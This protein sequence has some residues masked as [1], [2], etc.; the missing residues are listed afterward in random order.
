MTSKGRRFLWDHAL[1]VAAIS[2][3]LVVVAFFLLS[4][5]IPGWLLPP[6]AHDLLIRVVREGYDYTS[7]GV[8]VHF[9]VRD[10]RVEATVR[11]LAAPT[12]S[13][14]SLLLVDHTSMTVREILVAVPPTL[15]TND[16]PQTFIVGALGGRR[17]LAGLRAPDGFRLEH[18]N[19][20][21]P[22]FAGGVLGMTDA[23]VHRVT[24]V[25]RG[26]V[27]PI[28]L[29]PRYLHLSSVQVVGWLMP[30][31]HDGQR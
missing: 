31:D 3:P 9:N 11:P 8:G 24:L 10:G 28:T 20:R 27:V 4:S 2:L 18:R 14:T 21:G 22:G 12:Y 13:Q 25:N 30:G 1:V 19:Q 16:P 5:I 23:Y 26:R 17:V 7:P 15:A 29:P 6:P